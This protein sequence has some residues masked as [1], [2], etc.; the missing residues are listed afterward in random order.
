MNF[1]TNF[2]TRANRPSHE[3]APK[4]GAHAAPSRPAPGGCP[5]WGSAWH[6]CFRECGPL[7]AP[8]PPGPPASCSSR[9]HRQARTHACAHT[10]AHLRHTHTHIY[11][12]S[13]RS[14]DIIKAPLTQERPPPPPPLLAISPKGKKKKKKNLRIFPSSTVFRFALGCFDFFQTLHRWAERPSSQPAVSSEGPVTSAKQTAARSAGTGTRPELVGP[15]AARLP[16]R[17][18]GRAPA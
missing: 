11:H 8:R 5:L 16:P 6:R 2:S 1:S 7:T 13:K 3:A 12:V 14:I 18:V 4:R 9:S 15:A 10:C 17:L